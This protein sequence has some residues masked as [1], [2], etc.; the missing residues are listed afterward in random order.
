[1]KEISFIVTAYNKPI[2]MVKRCLDSIIK[3]NKNDSEI[4]F[5]NDGSQESYTKMYKRLVATYSTVNYFEKE[6]GG[7]SSARNYGLKKAVGRYVYFVDADDAIDSSA[8]NIINDC[9]QELVIFD[10]QMNM[11]NDSEIFRLNNKPGIMKSKDIISQTLK[12]GLLNWAI[13]KL[14]LKKYLLKNNLF[15]D[16]GKISGEDFDFVVKVLKS[17]P[18]I[19]YINKVS[20]IYYYQANT[21]LARIKENPKRVLGNTIDLFK[22]R[23]NIN[24]ECDGNLESH[25]KLD[26]LNSIFEIYGVSLI[27][28]YSA[29]DEIYDIILN[30]IRI[31]NFKKNELGKVSIFKLISLKNNNKLQIKWYTRLRIY[32]SKFKLK[33]FK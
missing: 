3:A 23:L 14:Y 15:F 12:N 29:S 21:N 10:V 16:N 5:I 7:V 28:K 33:K 27:Y 18:S 8:F 2:H 13:G 22:K 31:Y 4:I 17:S 11:G 32:L 25:I 26:F 1:M 30:Y 6:N 24:Y 19:K 20:Y 9:T